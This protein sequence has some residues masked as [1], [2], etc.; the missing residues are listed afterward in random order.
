MD[1]A[2]MEKTKMS[3][4]RLAGGFDARQPIDAKSC[5]LQALDI[6]LTRKWPISMHSAGLQWTGAVRAKS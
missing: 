1:N 2:S 3:R 6:T 5:A 4:W